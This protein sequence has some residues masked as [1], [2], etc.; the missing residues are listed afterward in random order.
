MRAK[1]AVG[2]G[3]MCRNR[4]VP[5]KPGAITRPK[6]KESASVTR[7]L[8][9][10][11]KEIAPGFEGMRRPRHMPPVPNARLARFFIMLRGTA[12]GFEGMR[13]YRHVPPVPTARLAR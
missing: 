5:S 4:R 3:D 1:R 10:L 6:K 7:R 12:P 9:F 8:F 13:R 11:G 2:T